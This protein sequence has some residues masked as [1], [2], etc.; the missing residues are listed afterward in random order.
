[1]ILIAGATGML[2]SEICR[3]LAERGKRIAALVRETSDAVRVAELEKMGADIR[4]GDLKDLASLESACAGIDTV[5]STVTAIHASNEGDN[6]VSVDRDGQIDLVRAS[7]AAGVRHFIY[8]SFP[9]MSESTPLQ[10]AKRAVEAALRESGMHYTILQPTFFTEIWL[11]PALGFDAANARAR[12][13]GT[14]EKKTS[15]ISFRDVAKFAAEAV[16][17]PAMAD[18]VIKLGGPDALSP[19]EVV[20]IFESVTGKHFE[21]EY[22]PEDALRAQHSAAAEP[23]QMTFAGLML[24]NVAGQPIEMRE[25]LEKFPIQLISVED[26]AR[27]FA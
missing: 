12:I 7:A 18:A 2:G 1:M 22:V 9:E 25:T 11:G 20:S 16:D 21:L 27:S 3:L 15:W 26:Y 24:N 14:G 10:D 17:N 13:F 4:R 23:R 5:I 8:I 6:L 19:L